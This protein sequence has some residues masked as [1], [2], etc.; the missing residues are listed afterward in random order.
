MKKNLLALLLGLGISIVLI[1]SLEVFFQI[2]A[3]THWVKRPVPRDPYSVKRPRGTVLS[4]NIYDKIKNDP[5]YNWKPLISEEEAKSIARHGLDLSKKGSLPCCMGRHNPTAPRTFESKVSTSDDH[6]LVYS[7]HFTFDSHGRRI[8]PQNPQNQY[9]ILMFGDSYTLGEGVNDEQSAPYQLGKFRPDSQVYNFG[10]SGG[11]PN[12]VLYELDDG[13]KLRISDIPK[14]KSIVL[15]SYMDHHLERL[16]ARSLAFQDEVNWLLTK[17]YYAEED[18]KVVYKGFFDHDRPALNAFYKIWNSSA[19]LNFFDVSWPP[20]FSKR[21]FDFFGDVLKSIENAAKKDFGDD[22][23]FYFVLYPGASDAF[24]PQL[25]KAA[26]E[27]GLKVLDYTDLDISKVTDGK[28]RIPIDRHP[29]PVT[30][31][32]FAWLLN[33]DLS[34]PNLAH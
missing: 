24:G 23:E 9:N 19:L 6:R 1:A 30:Q 29:S 31:F 13:K 14:K 20:Q 7:V 4:Q 27:R 2:N 18:G 33:R 22:T 8:T 17:P 21:H 10:I 12:D 11:G 3:A 25:K 5:I 16:F 15:Y 28:P 32:V 34:K 26:E